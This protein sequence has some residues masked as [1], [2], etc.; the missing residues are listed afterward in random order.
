MEIKLKNIL[1]N[2]INGIQIID[3]NWKYSYLNE[4]AINHSKSSREEL[5]GY[6]MMEK[7]PGIESTEMFKVLEECMLDRTTKSVVNEFTYPDGSKDWFEL[8]VQ[9]ISDGLLI[10]S[11]DIS[12]RIQVENELKIAKERAEENEQDISTIYNT[13]GNII[14]KLAVEPQNNY[15]FVSV[16]HEFVRSTGL[17]IESIIGQLVNDVIPEPSLSKV[18]EFYSKAIAENE[19]IR[20]EEVSDYPTGKLTGDVSV[21]P[22]YNTEGECTFL[23]G[24]VHDITLRKQAEVQLQRKK[25]ELEMLNDALTQ[26]NKE[27]TISKENAEKSEYKIKALTEQSPIAIYRTDVNGDYTYV[28]KKWLEITGQI[29]KDVLGKS[30]IN[31]VH[32]NDKSEIIKSWYEAVN[33]QMEWSSE[34]RMIN[35][36]DEI[37][38][39][40]GTATKLF[41]S[42]GDLIGYTG[43]NFDITDRKLAE[44]AVIENQRI[45][46]IGEMTSAIAHDINNSLQSISGNIMLATL[47]PNLDENVKRY[48]DNMSQIVA[49]AA[50]RAKIVQRFGG[51]NQNKQQ[52]SDLDINLLIE[53]IVSSSQHLWKDEVEKEGRSITVQREFN[54]LPK[55]LGVEGE[56]SAVFLNVLKNCI[57]AMP[58]GGEINIRTYL[59]NDCINI[60]VSDTGKGMDEGTKKRIFQPFFTT[61]GYDAGR[62]L[63]MSGAYSVLK[64]H[65]GRIWVER[66]ELGIGTTIIMA[67]PLNKP[68]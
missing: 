56:I 54:V 25:E 10:I 46:V 65:G 3:F 66:T 45:N 18:L 5:L 38:W 6:T 55:A 29:E 28:N 14:F 27:L 9:P 52:Y 35:K 44:K 16:N 30:W 57:E 12:K 26:T 32:P 67:L 13:V 62:G 7:H 33:E 4:V 42:G 40:E 22:I 49:D 8:K 63:G 68:E 19:T 20:W 39:V 15:R 58:N 59:D 51:A 47:Q 1:D 24:S 2:L 53:K 37:T 36:K 43:T 11:N 34:H 23:V 21:S 61:K 64:E 41:N 60:A 48:L 50:Q 17:S 31:V